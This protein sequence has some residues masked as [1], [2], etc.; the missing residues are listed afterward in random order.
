MNIVGREWAVNETELV[1]TVRHILLH[2]IEQITSHFS[3][4]V[5]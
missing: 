2:D 1:V 3:A 5:S 4:I